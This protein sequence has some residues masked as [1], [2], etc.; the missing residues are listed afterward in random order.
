MCFVISIA[1]SINMALLYGLSMRFRPINQRI[2]LWTWK[3]RLHRSA[4]FIGCG[5][6]P[7]AIPGN[8][9][10]H[11]TS[12]KYRNPQ[13][14][15]Q[16]TFCLSA[17]DTKTDVNKFQLIY[18]FPG[19]RMCK[20]VSRLKILQ[21][22]L[23]IMVLPPIYYYYLQGQVA[24]FVVFYFTGIS[25]FAG[26]MLYSLTYYLQR[27]IGMIYINQV[28][29]TLKISHLTFWGKRKDIFLP[30]EDVK[31]LSE[32]GDQKGEVLFQVRRYSSPDIL[33]ITTRFGQIVD[34]EK[35]CFIFG[36]IK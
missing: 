19:I 20:A 5:E 3:S 33:Y 32:T 22:M 11:F 25:V 10:S 29:T 27:I 31:A 14:L 30:V 7:Q 13:L 6:N 23:T 34:K 24:E 4:S 12:F 18:K 8:V 26:A 21:T 15:S 36:E 2:L 16:N 9:F 1:G 17:T 28:A 35:F